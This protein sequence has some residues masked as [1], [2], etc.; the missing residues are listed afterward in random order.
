M[1]VTLQPKATFVLSLASDSVRL[2][3]KQTDQGIVTEAKPG[4]PPAAKAEYPL[5][6]GD[7]QGVVVRARRTP[8]N[9]LWYV[10]EIPVATSPSMDPRGTANVTIRLLGIPGT[11]AQVDNIEVW[12]P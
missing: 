11:Q 5:I 1:N 9:I 3:L 10:N 2:T 12:Y 7:A 8:Y 6:P 4:S